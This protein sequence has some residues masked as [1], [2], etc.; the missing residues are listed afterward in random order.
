MSFFM[1]IRVDVALIFTFT[2]LIWL[3]LLLPF[4]FT[5]NKTSRSLLGILWG[6]LLGAIIFFNI[7]DILYFGFV[8]RHLNNELA[9]IGNDVGILVDMVMDFYL[10]QTIFGTIFYFVIIYFFYKVFNS[11]INNKTIKQKEWANMLLIIIIA[12]LG[13]RGKLDGISFGTSDAFAV[14]K[15]SSGNLALNGFFCFY[16]GGTIHNTDHSAVKPDLAIKKVK[17]AIASNRFKFIDNQYPLMRKSTSTSKNNYNF[18]IIMIES[19]SAKYLDE[20]AHNNFKVTP[21]LDKLAQQGQLFT[22]FFANGQRSQEGIT[23]I[24]TGMTQPV[25]FENLGEG[26]EL[27]NPSY[28]GAMA[29]KNGYSTLAMQSSDRG[30]FRVDK[31][32]SLAGFSEYYGAE[33]IKKT[34]SESGEPNYGAWDGNGFRFLSSKLKTIKEPFISFFFTA[35]THSPFY[36]P[37]KQWEK[38]PHDTKSENG[39]LNT[40]NYVDS[41]IQ[42]FLETSKKEPWFD[43]TIFIFTADHTNHTQLSNA[44]KIN[45]SKVYLNEFHV[46]LIIY[47]PKI[48]KPKISPIVSSHNDIIPT[49][50]DTLGWGNS[51]TTIGNSLFDDSVKNRFAFVK[52]GS[53]VGISDSNGSI[54]YNFKNLI[55]E[56]GSISREREE[57]LLSID[58]AQ[59]HLLKNSKWMKKD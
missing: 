13:I 28:L 9:L 36:S 14:N 22:N 42:E 58:S 27:Y 31:L 19:L 45:P 21:T 16:R 3:A 49:I 52:M 20:L 39:Y 12:F 15:I 4:K 2:S 11:N 7:G 37:G 48:I 24:Y 55:S 43:R 17:D 53:I 40:V 18:V 6:T 29:Q 38:Y 56:K 51:F 46:P 59:A 41:Q 33:D 54:F 47:A 25:G 1:G 10:L 35:S 50:I 57:L 44:K 34:G 5:T 26:L 23:S 30:S 8:N 32:S